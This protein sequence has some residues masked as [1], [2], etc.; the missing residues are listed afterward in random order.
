MPICY[1]LGSVNK[2]TEGNS[3]KK[4][5][6]IGDSISKGVVFD[7][8]KNKYV[9]L[10]ENFVNL[11]S[12]K[13]NA[14]IINA[15]KFGSTI[16]QGELILKSRVE[17]YDPDIVVIE[18][19]GNDCDY[20]WD[21]VANHPEV[22]HIPKTPLVQFEKGLHRMLDYILSHGKTPVLSTLPPL[23]ADNYFRWFTQNDEEKGKNVLKWLRDVWRIYWWQERY[24]NCIQ[25]ISKKRNI[26]CIDIRHAFL[27]RKE[28][29]D[30]V[31]ID[32]IHLNSAGHKVVFEE[33]FSF[34]KENA[35]YLLK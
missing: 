20:S 31:C 32:G 2:R 28:F 26:L 25:S 13:T 17:K 27:S 12:E 21:E 5:L 34:M 23:Y 4:I 7:E 8:I 24:S 29:D 16:K 22:D 35:A 18:L 6:V 11:I 19:G 15:S 30:C 9:L 14:Q 1:Y 33:I 3:M 10:K